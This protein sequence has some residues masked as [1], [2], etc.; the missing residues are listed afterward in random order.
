MPILKDL[1][2]ARKEIVAM[3]ETEALDLIR[4]LASSIPLARRRGKDG[5]YFS[6]MCTRDPVEKPKGRGPHFTGYELVFHIKPDQY[7]GLPEAKLA[8]RRKR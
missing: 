2:E 3:G 6:T 7:H 5:W 1:P 4:N 8:K